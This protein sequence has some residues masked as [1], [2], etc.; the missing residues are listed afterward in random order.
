MRL[1]NSKKTKKQTHTHTTLL[2]SLWFPLKMGISLSGTDCDCQTQQGI[3]LWAH[4]QYVHSHRLNCTGFLIPQGRFV[5]SELLWNGDLMDHRILFN[6]GSCLAKMGFDPGRSKDHKYLTAIPF[7]G[8]AKMIFQT[9]VYELST[10]Q[11]LYLCQKVQDF[12]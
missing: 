2:S 11:N 4:E 10:C 3:L 8:W 9:M 5:S 6:F 12:T 7:S 1:T